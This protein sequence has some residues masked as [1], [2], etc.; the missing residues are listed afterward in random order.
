[1][2]VTLFQILQWRHWLE[3][4]E[5]FGRSVKYK[6]RSVNA[7]VGRV[8][9]L[10]PRTKRQVT[11]TH[12]RAVERALKSAKAGLLDVCDVTPDNEGE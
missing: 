6:G 5:K 11:L 9:G 4:E 12:L 2:R 1:M 7:H 3:L 8:F 10:P